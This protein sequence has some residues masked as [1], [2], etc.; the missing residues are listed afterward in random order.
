MNKRYTVAVSD[1][2]TEHFARKDRAVKHGVESGKSFQIFSPNGAL[3]HSVTV[4]APEFNPG[5]LVTSLVDAAKEVK[6]SKAGYARLVGTDGK[7]LAW[8]NTNH[9]DFPDGKR[10]EVEGAL[11]YLQA[12]N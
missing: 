9:I 2:T 8:V 4:A 11:G 1:S 5:I 3:V 10:A 7:T 6:F 12:V